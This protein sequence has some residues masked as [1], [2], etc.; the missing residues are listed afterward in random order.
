MTVTEP[1]S[2][3][4]VTSWSFRPWIVASNHVLPGF[5]VQVQVLSRAPSCIFGIFGWFEQIQSL[6]DSNVLG[7]CE[8]RKEVLAKLFG[9]VVSRFRKSIFIEKFQRLAEF[10]QIETEVSV[11]ANTR[12][13]QILVVL[14]TPT[15]LH[16]AVPEFSNN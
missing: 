11:N 10:E 4:P 3:A 6:K 15:P 8:F 13:G 5:S 14:K 12:M 2:V 7:A 16:K 1:C 9:L